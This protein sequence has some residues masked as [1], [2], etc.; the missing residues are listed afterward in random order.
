[1]LRCYMTII[2]VLSDTHD[3][4]SRIS[5]PKCDLLIH[6]GDFSNLGK[7]HELASFNNWIGALKG[8]GTIKKAVVIPGNHDLSLEKSFQNARENLSEVDHILINGGIEFDG[9][10]I[11][12]V[13]YVPIFYDWA[14][15]RT[16]NE[17]FEKYYSQIPSG[18]DILVCH[19][20]PDDI[21]DR[22]VMKQRTG[23]KAMAALIEN[24]APRY[25]LCGHIHESRGV[26]KNNKTVFINAASV[27]KNYLP[28]APF[29]FDI[30]LNKP[31]I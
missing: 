10:K 25:F 11:W 22:N 31:T 28:L 26:A 2:C 7:Y 24:L 9:L 8:N 15:M 13:S 6:C 1:M 17:L 18:L 14:F 16:E 30:S 20:P 29:I 5:I 3:Q 27:D 21:L 23:S 19:G 4:H 12:G